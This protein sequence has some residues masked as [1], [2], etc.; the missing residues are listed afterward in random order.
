L[1]ALLLEELVDLSRFKE[2][3]EDHPKEREYIRKED[4]SVGNLLYIDIIC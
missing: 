3:L 2:H 4:K 1:L